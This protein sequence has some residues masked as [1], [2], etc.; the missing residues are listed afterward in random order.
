MAEAPE[1]LKSSPPGLHTGIE[2]DDFS[3]SHFALTGTAPNILYIPPGAYMSGGG[4]TENK[5]LWDPTSAV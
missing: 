2:W 1:P 3:P 5:K 4:P